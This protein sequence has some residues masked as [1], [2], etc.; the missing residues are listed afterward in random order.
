MPLTC[1]DDGS[2]DIYVRPR[3]GEEANWLP[4]RERAVQPHGP[5]LLVKAR[6][7]TAPEAAASDAPGRSLEK[8][9]EMKLSAQVPPG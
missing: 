7:S 9:Q 3:L 6:R 1:N 4:R 8:E 5:D 2:L